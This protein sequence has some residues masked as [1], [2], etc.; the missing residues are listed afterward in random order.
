MG[1]M[2]FAI[3]FAFFLTAFI[4]VLAIVNPLSTVGL[5]LSL[6][7]NAH[8]RERNKI[9]FNASLLALCVLIFFS[10]TGFLVFQLYSIT[11]DSF[12]IAGGMVL[13]VIGMRMLFPPKS[14]GHTEDYAGQQI[15]IVPLGIPMTS[16]PG[17]ITTVVVLASTATGVW[18]EF[19]LWLAIFL[20]CAVNY[21]VLR[22]SSI[23][24]R[25]LGNEGVS[26]LVKI[27]GLLVCAVGVEFM[28]RG[29]KVVFPILAG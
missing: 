12:R 3:D 27:M 26:A 8:P 13:L 15:Y 2:D 22:F 28:I 25:T 10:L 6:T 29:I 9:S 21:V 4:S 7:K 24:Q 1:I 16:G 5:L 11:I 20:A 14:T 19:S 23:I 18:Q 17:A